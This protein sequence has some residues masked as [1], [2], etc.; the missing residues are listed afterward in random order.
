MC[1]QLGDRLLGHP[2]LLGDQ[3]HHVLQP[4]EALLQGL[5]L[6]AASL[7]PVPFPPGLG[8]VLGWGS[9]DRGGGPLGRDLQ[10]FPARPQT[11]DA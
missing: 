1:G 8:L 3:Q 10:S 4:L 6:G 2:H 5:Q 9:M 11:G 7:A